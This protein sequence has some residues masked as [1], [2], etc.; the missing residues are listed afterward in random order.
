MSACFGKKVG[1]FTPAEFDNVVFQQLLGPVLGLQFFG[2]A[3]VH[4]GTRNTG[5]T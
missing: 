3:T 5:R 1:V 2:D 4:H